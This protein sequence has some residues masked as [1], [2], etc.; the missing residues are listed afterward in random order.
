MFANAFSNEAI[1]SGNPAPNVSRSRWKASAEFG[2]PP[3]RRRRVYAAFRKLEPRGRPWEAWEEPL[4]HLSRYPA[5]QFPVGRI[6]VRPAAYPNRG[7]R[8][9]KS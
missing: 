1:R 4:P 2:S 5:Y 3:M 9:K 8:E 7:R 6:K